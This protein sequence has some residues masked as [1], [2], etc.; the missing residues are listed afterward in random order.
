MRVI[1]LLWPSAPCRGEGLLRRPVR[2]GGRRAGRGG[3]GGG[4]GGGARVGAR[5]RDRG[6]IA[7][8]GNVRDDVG[9]AVAADVDVAG[10]AVGVHLGAGLEG[11]E[12]EVGQ[13]VLV[14]ARG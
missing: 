10:P 13:R 9:E 7:G 12:D 8:G 3:G 5:Q 4:G 2:A 14:L 1:R 11:V 6:G